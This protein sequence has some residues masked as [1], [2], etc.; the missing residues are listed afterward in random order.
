MPLTS[1]S[2]VPDFAKVAEAS[3]AHAETVSRGEELAAALKRA[4]NH[5]DT[6]RGAALLN[7][8]VRA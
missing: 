1:L 7:V 6:N 5:I 8:H 2:P 3:N 4:I